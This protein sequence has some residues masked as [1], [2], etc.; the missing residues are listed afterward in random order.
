LGFVHQGLWKKERVVK[1]G[2][3]ESEEPS[4]KGKELM[5]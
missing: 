4:T 2:A 1:R 5:A 3:G